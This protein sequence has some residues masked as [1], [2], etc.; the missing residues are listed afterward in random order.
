MITGIYVTDKKDCNVLKFIGIGANEYAEK[1]K[2]K[3]TS[4]DLSK[5]KKQI[6]VEKPTYDDDG[7]LI[8]VNRHTLKGLLMMPGC[9]GEVLEDEQYYYAMCCI[10]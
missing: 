3:A 7:I 9:V 1:L 8:N 2:S 4:V 10:V 6:N 5:L